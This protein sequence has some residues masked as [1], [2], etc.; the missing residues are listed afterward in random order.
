MPSTVEFLDAPTTD[1]RQ[2][3]TAKQVA[4]RDQVSV[5]TVH[6]RRK[7]GEYAGAVLEG[8]S[9]RF[10][11][12]CRWVASTGAVSAATAAAVAADALVALRAWRAA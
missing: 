4:F 10:P 2:R 1:L 7:R 11:P 6:E 8:R 9:Y 3:L 5:D 12:D